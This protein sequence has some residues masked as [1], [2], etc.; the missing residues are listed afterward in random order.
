MRPR[1]SDVSFGSGK[2]SGQVLFGLKDITEWEVVMVNKT[3]SNHNDTFWGSLDDDVIYGIGGDDSIF[4]SDGDDQIYGGSGDDILRAGAGNDTLVGG[5]GDDIL[6]VYTGREKIDGGSGIDF[7]DFYW[8]GR[9]LVVDL[10][11]QKTAY[12]IGSH[13][14]DVTFKGIEAVLGSAFDDRIYGDGGRNILRGV[15]GDDTLDGRGGDDFIH[16]GDGDERMTGG[17]GRDMFLFGSA[18][19]PKTNFDRVTDFHSGQDHLALDLDVF[20]LDGAGKTT[21]I[22]DIDYQQLKA[23]EFQ[24]GTGH[25]AKTADIRI[26]YDTA[27]GILYS[28]S[29]GSK[30]GHLSE[31]AFIG[32]GLDISADMLFVYWI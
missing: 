4:G 14:Y 6:T 10:V 3:L 28:D 15:G 31:I 17:A 32:K 30:A 26:L 8:A 11:R 24:S 18:P 21:H 1:A 29:N 19:D 12:D 7:I 16:S 22:A 20:D 5:T 13:R 23:S 9:G 25:V 27:S 2:W